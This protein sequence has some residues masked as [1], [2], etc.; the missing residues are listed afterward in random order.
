MNSSRNRGLLGMFTSK[1]KCSSQ[2]QYYGLDLFFREIQDGKG[3]VQPKNILLVI[4][5]IGVIFSKESFHH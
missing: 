1:K 2:Y 5:N 3:R 4:D